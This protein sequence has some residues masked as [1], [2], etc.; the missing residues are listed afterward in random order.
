MKM[1]SESGFPQEIQAEDY[2][3]SK[4][5]LKRVKKSSLRL[6]EHPESAD[7]FNMNLEE[8]H[9]SLRIKPGLLER[10]LIA[11]AGFIDDSVIRTKKSAVVYYMLLRTL[12]CPRV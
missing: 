1:D 8:A 3:R 7:L 4:N 5:A 11:K 12:I 2:K 10:I 9:R 6:S